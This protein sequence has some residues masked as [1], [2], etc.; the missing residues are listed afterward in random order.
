[1]IIPSFKTLTTG[2]VYT[3]LDSETWG[4][5]VENKTAI[6][7][8][9]LKPED[10]FIYLDELIDSTNRFN[11]IFCRGK[12]LFVAKFMCYKVKEVCK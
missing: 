9:V 10:K 5:I 6:F 2:K 11:K 8:C 4:F 1:M 12:I 7:C 3:N